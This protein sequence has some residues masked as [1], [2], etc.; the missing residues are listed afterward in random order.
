MKRAVGTS[1]IVALMVSVMVSLMPL[2]SAAETLRGADTKK[3]VDDTAWRAAGACVLAAGVAV[4]GSALSIGALS[5]FTLPVAGKACLTFTIL[6]LG[7]ALSAEPDDGKQPIQPTDWE[8]PS[9]PTDWEKFFQPIDWEQFFQPNRPTG[10]C[11]PS[12]PTGRSSSNRLTGSS[13][14]NRPTGSCPPSRPTGRS[15]SNRLTGSRPPSRSL[16]WHDL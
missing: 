9:E 15:S 8:L 4:T 10:S 3:I 13:S 6:N 5:W 12:R 16:I 11:P 2:E 14:S 1:T 7:A